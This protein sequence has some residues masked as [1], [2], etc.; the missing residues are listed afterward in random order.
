M[1]GHVSLPDAQSKIHWRYTSVG[2]SVEKPHNGIE[3]SSSRLV[4]LGQKSVF[5][6]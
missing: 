5:C 2:E 1:L 3:M 6:I 4:S